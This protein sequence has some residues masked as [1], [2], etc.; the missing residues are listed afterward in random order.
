M[1]Q[2]RA[3]AVVLLLAASGAITRAAVGVPLTPP[4]LSALPYVFDGWRGGEAP[5]LDDET[6]RILAAD[7]VLNRNYAGA[8]RAP[9]GLYVAYYARQR[10]GVSIHS[11][12]HCLPGTGWEALAVDTLSFE[13]SGSPGGTMRRMVVGR[14]HQRALVLYWYSLH[15]RGIAS[16]VTTK[17]W[18]LADSVRLHRSDAAMVRIVVPIGRS[19]QAANE[20]GQAFARDLAPRM[21]DILK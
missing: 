17:L 9:I 11:P 14:G 15:G 16:E 10:P 12:L 2:A 20:Q 8:D 21:V 3:I 5:A 19:V 7:E 6:L 1:N 13:A 18:Q 4:H